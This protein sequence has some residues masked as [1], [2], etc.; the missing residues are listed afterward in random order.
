MRVTTRVR[1][2]LRA[3]MQ[4]AEAYP[5]GPVSIS[6][7][8]RHQSISGKYLEQLVGCLRRHALIG[9]RKGVRGGYYLTRPPAEISLWEVISALDG[10]TD[11]VECVGR[12]ELCE[13][14][15]NCCTRVVWASLGTRLRDFWG[16]FS[17]QDLLDYLPEG[18]D[19]LLP[20][21][22]AQP[23]AASAANPAH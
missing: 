10:E 21:A 18:C 8:S 5:G 12:P 2:G 19:S 9:S 3:M 4:I 14:S 11:L 7:I 13:R 1:Y 16:T 17:I 15:Q 22:R 23:T 6:A 20:C